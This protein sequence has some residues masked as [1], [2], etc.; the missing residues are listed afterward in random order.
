MCR[1]GVFWWLN[2]DLQVCMVLFSSTKSEC[3]HLFGVSHEQHIAYEHRMVPRFALYRRH[4]GDL[5][6]L[7]AAGLNECEF[8]FLRQHEQ[9][10]LIGQQHKL[11]IAVA[12]ALPLAL[13]ITEIDA[14]ENAAVESERI[15]LMDHEVVEVRLQTV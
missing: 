10:I 4:F 11:A 7:I 9:Q 1:E 14:R 5:R 2:S 3:C 13:T 6:K 12:S 8:A 15:A